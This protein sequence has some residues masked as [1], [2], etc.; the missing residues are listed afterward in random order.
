MMFAARY[1]PALS[2]NLRF[3]AETSGAMPKSAATAPRSSDDA[4]KR[5]ERGRTR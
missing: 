5:I 2:G 4:P 3:A 1:F